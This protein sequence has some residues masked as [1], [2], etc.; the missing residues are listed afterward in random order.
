[1]TFVTALREPWERMAT[2][3]EEPAHVREALR[4]MRGMRVGD[5]RTNS[6]HLLG[7]WGFLGE[8]EPEFGALYFDNYYTRVLLG[9]A[10]GTALPWG[11]IN[12]RHFERARARLAAFDLVWTTEALSN[13]LPAFQRMAGSCFDLFG[14]S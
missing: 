11:A 14:G 8:G 9:S 12:V 6:S 4:L 10:A 2:E 1:M 5:T 7:S 13:A 3:F